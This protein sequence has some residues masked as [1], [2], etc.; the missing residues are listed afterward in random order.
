MIR[1]PE[2][3]EAEWTSAAASVSATVTLRKEIERATLVEKELERLRIRHEAKL[4]HQQELDAENTPSLEMMTVQDYLNSPTLVPTDLI[5]GV[6]KE[7]GL[8]VVMGPSGHGKTSITL[9]MVHSLLTGV[10]WLGQSVTKVSGVGIA[11]YDMD[12]STL[13]DWL[14]GMPNLDPTSVSVVDA[15]RRGN[16][17]GVPAYRAKIAEAWRR[18]KVEVV[19]V[20]TFSASFFGSD[21][22]DAAAVM[23]HYRDLKL[24]A[25]TEVGA[26]GL[27]V[28]SHSTADRPDK[29]RGSSVHKDTSDCMVA[30]HM[31]KDGQQEVRMEKYR[32]A[33][34]VVEMTPR[35][36]EKPDDVT[37]LTRPDLGAMSL[38]G[39]PIP[40]SMAFDLPESFE[41]P[42]AG[43]PG[44]DDS[45]TES[46]EEDWDL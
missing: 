40:P 7:N 44:F 8:T 3:V 13:M 26:R 30:V 17:L 22:N 1:F 32:A 25:L 4:L 6:M 38:A 20:D 28:L 21:Q 29:V 15:Y 43:V 9:Q 35:I 36:T 16:P 37:H 18:M 41:E 23:S 10:D 14:S 42:E 24:F 2:T 12:C 19:V 33:R 34:G 5:D 11:S 46:E 39:Y 27:I 45:F 31:N